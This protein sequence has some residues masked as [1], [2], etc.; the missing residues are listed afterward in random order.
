M[1][2]SIMV[3]AALSPQA[4]LR[5]S[6]NASAVALFLWRGSRVRC[7]GFPWLPANHCDFSQKAPRVQYC[8]GQE[9][10]R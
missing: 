7:C 4:L 10:D 2:S 9:N 8:L 5:W 1:L 3:S 6:L